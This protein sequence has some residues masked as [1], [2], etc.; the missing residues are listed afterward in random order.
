M[1]VTGA[2][3]GELLNA[4]TGQGSFTLRDG[5]VAGLHAAKSIQGFT[6]VEHLFAPGRSGGGGLLETTFSVIEGD[7]SIHG[8]RIYT[9]K[10]RA[11]TKDGTGDIHGSIGFDQ[12]LDLAGTWKLAGAGGQQGGTSGKNIFGK[13][14]G[15]VAKHSVGELPI[16][17]SV[18]GT[19]K[20]PKILP[21]EAPQ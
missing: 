7:L 19:V 17:F 9:T 20:D 8:G 6:K 11:E 13:V 15:K 3:G 12:T 18:K 1:Q 16:P 14:F 2:I 5:T 4:I 21:G 10:T